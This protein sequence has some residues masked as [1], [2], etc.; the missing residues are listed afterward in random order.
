LDESRLKKELE[1][2]E[3]TIQFQNI[4]IQVFGVVY[5]VIAVVAGFL[6]F[7]SFRPLF[8]RAEQSIDR[9]DRATERLDSRIDNF[10]Q[11]A[12]HSIERTDNATQRLDSRIDNFIKDVDRKIK[13]RFEEFEKQMEVKILEDLFKDIESNL[14]T[15][16]KLAIER[17]SLLNH[18][19]L[20]P[21]KVDRLFQLIDKKLADEE[22]KIIVDK[23]IQ[24]NTYQVKTYFQIWSN[25]EVGNDALKDRLYYYYIANKF[26]NYMI[27]IGKFVLAHN[28]PHIELN[29]LLGL[30][31]SHSTE[32]Y[33]IL[34]YKPLINSLD[35]YSKAQVVKFLDENV[36]AWSLINAGTVSAS[37]LY[38]E[39][40]PIS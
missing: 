33:Y 27:P 11:Q 28:A 9:T 12:E 23:L 17:L 39:T 16:R 7:F 26:E 29:R 31:P 20:A 2:A 37:L 5:A 30:L 32:F 24:I 8:N 36:K 6:Y 19:V 4:W 21:D 15:Q 38:S 22:Q 1:T 13:E 35:N 3:T 25:V 40:K 14:A 10:I 18:S 34:N